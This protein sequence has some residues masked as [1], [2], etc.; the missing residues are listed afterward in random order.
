M[1]EVKDIIIKVIPASIANPFV[2]R[3]HY[4]GKVVQNSQLHFGAF[5]DG[6]LHGVLSYG[7]SMRKDKIQ[8][9]VKGTGWNEFLEL[10]R[11]AFDEYLPR[12][13]ESYAIAKS[14]RLIKKNAPQIKW[15]VSF[16]DG[17]QCGDGTIYRAANFV[18]TGIS[19][20]STIILLPDGS[21]VAG[22]TLTAHPNTQETRR[23]KL[24]CGVPINVNASLSAYLQGG[25]KKMDGYMLRY[26]YFIDKSCREKLTV[27]IIPFSAIDEVGA[28]MYKG[29]NITRAERHAKRQPE[30]CPD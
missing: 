4:S 28:G 7:P 29:E 5:L 15:I 30:G 26:I 6:K 18:L 19:K 24:L 1:G 27:P 21:R 22:L 25:A 10:N 8:P 20:N 17:T 11:M 13:S 16:A 12:N 2:K 9:L 23:A 3:V 14:I